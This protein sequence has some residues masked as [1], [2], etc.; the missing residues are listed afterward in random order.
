MVEGLKIRGITGTPP[1]STQPRAGH[2]FI[3]PAANPSSVRGQNLRNTQAK[4]VVKVIVTG[5]LPEKTLCSIMA[6]PF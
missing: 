2:A 5:T 6:M 4:P 1:G 3:G